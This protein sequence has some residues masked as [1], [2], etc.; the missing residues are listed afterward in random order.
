VEEFEKNEGGRYFYLNNDLRNF[1]WENIS[2][3]SY[4]FPDLKEWT[5]DKQIRQSGVLEFLQSIFPD[6]EFPVK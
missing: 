6:L 4:E 1:N 2:A 3:F 5:W